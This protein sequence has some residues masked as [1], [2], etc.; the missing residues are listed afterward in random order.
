MFKSK[1][2]I[3]FE[4]IASQI[5]V[6]YIWSPGDNKSRAQLYLLSQLSDGKPELNI[7]A[8]AI[9]TNHE[10]LSETKYSID[11]HIQLIYTEK[12]ELT[13]LDTSHLPLILVIDGKGV[14]KFKHSFIDE[15][16]INLVMVEVE[17]LKIMN[18]AN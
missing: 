4:T 18:T 16:T 12:P 7:Y 5:S 13:G 10:N 1:T 15:D 9:N 6:L 14:I 17:K 3:P 8:L 2:E 11:P